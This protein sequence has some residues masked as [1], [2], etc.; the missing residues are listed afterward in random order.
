[1]ATRFASEKR[2]IALCDRC[3]FRYPLKK[4][5]TYVILGNVVNQRVCPTCWEPDNI[6]NWVGIIGGRKAADDPQALRNPR[7]DTNLNESRGLF[8]WNPVAIQQVNTT[9]NSVNIEVS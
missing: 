3:G 7:P 8:A 5:R 9:V 2:A 6:R 1:M 4:L